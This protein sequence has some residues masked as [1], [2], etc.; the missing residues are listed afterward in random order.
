MVNTVQ[1]NA[2]HWRNDEC[3]CMYACMFVRTYVCMNACMYACIHVGREV[4]RRLFS[5]VAAF[6]QCATFLAAFN[7]ATCSDVV[8]LR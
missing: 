8:L 2:D 6:I 7:P 4:K 3:V 5:I 1:V